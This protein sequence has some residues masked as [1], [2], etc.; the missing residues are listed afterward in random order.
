[1]RRLPFALVATAIVIGCGGEDDPAPSPPLPRR[2]VTLDVATDSS[3]AQVSERYLSVAIDTAQ[4]LG[5]KFWSKDGEVMSIVGDETRP[6]YDFGRPLLQAL[7]GELAPAWL[8]VGGSAADVTYYDLGAQPVSEAP[9]PYELLLTAERWDSIVGFAAA[10]DFELLFT[11]NAGAGPRDVDQAW[12]DDQARSLLEYAAAHDQEVGVWELGNEI[13]GYPFILGPD[14]GVD[15]EQYASDFAV[16][17]QLVDELAPEALL[18]GPSSA[19]WPLGGEI[20][21]ILEDWLD[22]AGE[23]VDVVTW[24][25]YPQQSRRC[26]IAELRA[27]PEMPLTPE[28]LDNAAQW[29]AVVEAAQAEHAPA[30]PVW[31]GETGGAQCGGEPG[32]SDAFVGGFWWLDQL[33]LVAS[34][35]QPVTIRQSLTG[36]SYG[37]LDEDTLEPRPDFYNSVLFRRLMG[38]EVLSASAEDDQDLIRSYAHCTRAGAPGA[39]SGAV[40]ILVLNLSTT[41]VAEV[42]FAELD[43]TDALVWRL[44]ADRLA[45]P[46]IRLNDQ[47]LSLDDGAMPDLEPIPLAAE[48]LA[49]PPPAY[50]FV[51]LP[52]AGAAACP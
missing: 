13:N 2:P 48:T 14:S 44:S 35:G 52:A 7:A 25:Y 22:L 20:N 40:T 17:R 18:A 3:V 32:L 5:G 33:G 47:S 24:H 19:Y 43:T 41:H 16:A 9:E 46:T 37:L 27:S 26:P 1:M 11:L 21:P 42:S 12:T 4:V 15:A 39:G 36:A 29:A 45:A 51:V 49:L 31:L 34:R 23:H 38:T 10:L 30:A 50:A 6:P 8:R 28:L